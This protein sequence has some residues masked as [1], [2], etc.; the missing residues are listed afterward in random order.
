MNSIDEYFQQQKELTQNIIK[1]GA[2]SIK[3]SSKKASESPFSAS[4]AFSLGLTDLLG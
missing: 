3:A 4:V 1:T 2:E